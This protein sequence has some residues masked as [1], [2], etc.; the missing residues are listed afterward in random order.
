MAKEKPYVAVYS[1]VGSEA[2]IGKKLNNIHAAI[3]AEEQNMKDLA[4][5]FMKSSDR[6]NRLRATQRTLTAQLF[7]LKQRPEADKK[8]G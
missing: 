4:A 2:Q 1:R 5:Q 6:Y 7:T 3:I 8:R